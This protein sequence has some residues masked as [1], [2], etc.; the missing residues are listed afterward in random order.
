MDSIHFEVAGDRQV[1]LRFDEFPDALRG[2]LLTKIE[3]LSAELY[4]RIVA[5]TPSLT[6]LLRSEER[7]RVLQNKDR[8]TGLVDI[9]APKGSKEFGK[10][11]ALEYGA[12][13]PAKVSAHMMQL[14]HHWANKLAR[15]QR[16]MVDAYTRTTN[17]MEH[18]F[19]RGP[20]A[21]MQPQILAAL[22]DSVEKTTAEANR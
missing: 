15:P 16:V 8:I 1:G 9:N 22:N 14:D 4:A 10:A 6:G 18:A 2:D 21:S 20:L 5:A 3:A 12:D 17:I 11:A 7:L 13:G 19:E